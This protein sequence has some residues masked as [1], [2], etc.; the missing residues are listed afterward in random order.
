MEE[1]RYINLSLPI[2]L[3]PYSSSL[4]QRPGPPNYNPIDTQ[5][6]FELVPIMGRFN[7]LLEQDGWTMYKPKTMTQPPNA[8]G[9]IHIDSSTAQDNNIISLGLNFPIANGASSITRWYDFSGLELDIT[10][11]FFGINPTGNLPEEISTLKPQQLV[12]RF[13]VDTMLLEQPCLFFSGQPHNVDSRHSSSCRSML[14]IRLV[15][16]D[17]PG[18][19]VSWD[20]RTE[21][22]QA[23]NS[24]GAQL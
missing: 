19:L 12:D 3:A 17:R 14:S 2:D 7:S 4:I 6:L 9:G 22:A 1:L 16:V 20:S 8:W 24:I 10:Q 5:L 21:I 23:I 13:C 15:A 18:Q 11:F